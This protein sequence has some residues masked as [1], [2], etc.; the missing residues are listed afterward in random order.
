MTAIRKMLGKKQFDKLFSSFINKPKGKPTLA[1]QSDK[2]PVWNTAQE[3]YK[4]E[5]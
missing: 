1:P 5:N 3:D 4:E 2:R